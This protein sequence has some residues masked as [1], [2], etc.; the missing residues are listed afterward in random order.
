MNYTGMITT[1]TI[2]VSS[3][4]TKLIKLILLI[5]I[6]YKCV[7]AITVY[8]LIALSLTGQIKMP[9]CESIMHKAININQTLS[10]NTSVFIQYHC[11]FTSHGNLVKLFLNLAIYN[12]V[13]LIETWN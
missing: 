4:P 10:I 9:V 2:W 12:Y 3:N 6:Q 8:N 13:T 11:V 1:Q 5:P 7:G